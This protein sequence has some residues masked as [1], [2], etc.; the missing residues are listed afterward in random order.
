MGAEQNYEKDQAIK[1]LGLKESLKLP[2]MKKYFWDQ[3]ERGFIFDT[4]LAGV[5]KPFANEGKRQEALILFHD[6]MAASPETFL[7]MYREFRGE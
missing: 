7:E 1:I 3:L 6:I 2:G 4:I 5:N